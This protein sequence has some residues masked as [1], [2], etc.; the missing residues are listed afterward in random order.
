[1]S[2]HSHPGFPSGLRHTFASS[3]WLSGLLRSCN[4]LSQLSSRRFAALFPCSFFVFWFL[5]VVLIRPFAPRTHARGGVSEGAPF[6]FLSHGVGGQFMA[7]LAYRLKQVAAAL[8]WGFDLG[9]GGVL[10][11]QE[12]A[13]LGPKGSPPF[14]FASGSWSCCSACT[15]VDVSSKMRQRSRVPWHTLRSLRRGAQHRAAGGVRQRRPSPKCANPLR[16]RLSHA[17]PWHPSSH[18]TFYRRLDL[19]EASI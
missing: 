18:C 14:P 4:S 5:C 1:M 7:L 6:G 13:S 3:L 11:H 8:V 19:D 12:I 10:L 17:A 16:R 9:A 2:V 15:L